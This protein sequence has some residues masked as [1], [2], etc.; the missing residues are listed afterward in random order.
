MQI[1][2]DTFELRRKNDP[3]G[4]IE[5]LIAQTIRQAKSIHELNQKLL[6]LGKEYQILKK[7]MPEE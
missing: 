4:L 3:Q 2:T 6:Q 1:G 5:D 7:Q